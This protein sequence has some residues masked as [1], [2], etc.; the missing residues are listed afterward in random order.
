MTRRD[1]RT[2]SREPERKR[3]AVYYDGKCPMCAAI[4]DSVRNSA[5]CADFDLRDMHTEKSLP[6]G[7]EA[8]E[9]EIH[10]KDQDGNLH[11]GAAAVLRIADQYAHLRIV[12]RLGRMP[13]CRTAAPLLY[14]LIAANRRFLAGPASRIFWL[15]TTI[16]LAFCVGLYLS[17]HLWMGPRSYP[18]AP[19]SN[20]LPAINEPL[21]YGLFGALFALSAAIIVSPKPQKFIAVLLAI[22][23][24]FCLLDQTRWQP[25]VL[26]YGFLLAVLGI[27]SWDIDDKS[28]QKRTLNMARLVVASTYVLSGLQKLNLNFI[29]NDF[30]WIA[31]PI[32]HMFPLATGMAHLVGAAVPFVQVAFGVGL[33]TRR[34]R[35]VSLIAA[36]SMH[37]FI[38]VMFG[39]LG[40]DWNEIVWPWTAAMAVFD[41]LLF[42]DATELSARE[43]LTGKD[44]PYYAVALALFAVLPFLSFFNLWD[45]YLSSALYSGNLTEAEIYTTDAGKD[46]LPTTI[47]PY[48]THTSPD[49][50]VLNIQHW[51]IEDLNVTP[52]PETRV[53]K[54]IAKSVCSRLNDPSQLVLVVREH[55]MFFSGPESGY[56][57]WDL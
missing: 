17:K 49:T 31:Q 28:G 21:G 14:G 40:L 8:I 5:K 26:Q 19:I 35:R 47:R 57:C 22:L 48:L 12:A 7:R 3:L 2:V 44:F 32:T 13:L 25:W 15:K 38:L 56:R 50:N 1:G 6:F 30:P 42:T 46:A 41:I 45:S 4:M 16:I 53:Y 27:F 10:V 43:I 39:P 33:L 37:V 51:A 23:A 20:L 55:R 54:S 9:K 52:Y 11:K 29:Q 24:V 34:F 36:V 18:P